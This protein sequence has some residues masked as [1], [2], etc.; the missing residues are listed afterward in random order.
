VEILAAIDATFRELSCPYMLV[1]AMAR[2]LL[3]YHVYGGPLPSRRTRHIDFAIAVD[4]W[5]I[6]AGVRDALLALDQVSP[7]KVQHRLRYTSTTVSDAEVDII[8]FGKIASADGSIS[9]PPEFETVMSVAGFEE[10]LKAS[11]SIAITDSLSMPVVSLPGLA[12]LKLFA[13]S[14]R[15][16]DRDATDLDR[17]IRSYAD[18]GN[19]DRLYDSSLAEEFGFDLDPAGARLLGMDAAVLCKSETLEKLTEIFTSQ[20]VEELVH[21]ATPRRLDNSASRTAELVNAFLEPIRRLIE[22]ATRSSLV[23]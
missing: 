22:P 13:W 4:S 12:I 2:D 6:F 7:T 5:K 15:N 21:Q 14:D 20:R 19:E 18:A 9:W 10:A 11:V 1:G 16:E 8:P 23:V 17:V 3:L